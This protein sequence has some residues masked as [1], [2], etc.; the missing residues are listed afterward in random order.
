MNK[1]TDKEVLGFIKSESSSFVPDD[2][3]AI[4]AK[5]GIYS[6]VK[7]REDLAIAEK[8]KN[9]GDAIVP[10][11]EDEVYAE[12][13]AKKKFSFGLFMRKRG[14]AIMAG[15]AAVAAVAVS[16]ST[17]GGTTPTVAAEG[18]IIT[19]SFE[20][21]QTVSNTADGTTTLSLFGQHENS[22]SY[23][24]SFTFYSDA[25]DMA[26]A[27]SLV[28]SS[29]SASLI[30]DSES[31][32]FDSLTNAKTDVFASGLLAPT[33]NMGY[34]RR[35]GSHH[36]SITVYYLT[37]DPGFDEEMAAIEE[38]I[39]ATLPD[40]VSADIAFEPIADEN[41]SEALLK[42]DD[43]AKF[44]EVAYIYNALSQV[45]ETDAKISIE[46]LANE[47]DDVLEALRNAIL[48]ISASRLGPYALDSALSGLALS[49]SKYVEGG[50]RSADYAILSQLK[51]ELMEQC[52]WLGWVNDEVR[53]SVA[54]YF[55]DDAY[56]LYANR[57]LESLAADYESGLGIFS[58]G[59]SLSYYFHIR[60]VIL[61]GIDKD[62]YLALLEAAATRAE[63]TAPTGPTAFPDGCYDLGPDE[64]HGSDG[65]Y[66]GENGEHAGEGDNGNGY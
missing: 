31:A 62:S 66:D 7:S 24:P 35:D 45:R 20:S 55:N 11:V 13:G 5:L 14:W 3:A 57:K 40:G 17:I 59:A 39:S 30:R 54:G 22:Y 27:S 51:S 25:D 65:G 61:Q 9:E 49:Y 42:L 8:V 15:A 46:A 53:A 60:D 33:Y 37:T 50:E 10:D 38:S 21:P 48:S 16:L 28:C 32:F 12:T 52:G 64:G 43:T 1:V 23:V 19:M 47:D 58:E 2:L 36:N 34:L 29:Y 26:D 6:P 44:K 56:Y 18:T 4:Q 63:E 41:V